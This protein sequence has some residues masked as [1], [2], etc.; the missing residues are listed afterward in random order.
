MSL[1]RRSSVFDPFADFW[2]PFNDI[3]RSVVPAGVSPDRD[4][5]SFVNAPIYWKET[6]RAHVFK[7]DLPGVQKEEVKVKVEDGNFLV[8]SGERTKEKGAKNAKW[9]RVERS[10]GKFRRRFP[11]PENTK[12]D[13]VKAG[14]ENGVFPVPVPKAEVK[15]PEVKAIEVSG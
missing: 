9:P 6:P 4:A 5:A 2:D 14:L 15:N 1:V 3:F 11:L 12:T 8:I 7:A 13:Q 10:S